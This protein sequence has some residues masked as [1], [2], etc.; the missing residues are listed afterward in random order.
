MKIR[1]F[2]CRLKLTFKNNKSKIVWLNTDKEDIIEAIDEIIQER[3]KFQLFF[4]DKN[5]PSAVFVDMMEV[6][7]IEVI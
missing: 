3:L 7:E 2:S 5:V 6:R 4:T 1:D